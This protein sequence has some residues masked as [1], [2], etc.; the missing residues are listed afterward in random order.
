MH[1][2]QRSLDEA[3]T[4]A[5][6]RQHVVCCTGASCRIRSRLAQYR[7]SRL[8]CVLT[9]ALMGD[10]VGGMLGR[11]RVSEGE[12]ATMVCKSLRCVD[13]MP[14]KSNGCKTCKAY[15]MGLQ[16]HGLSCKQSYAPSVF[17]ASFTALAI[18]L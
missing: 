9:Q 8:H 13:G 14:N 3:N 10:P 16:R 6:M 18:C 1:V 4:W 11:N 7:T 5:P 12:G 2:G 17:V 15:A